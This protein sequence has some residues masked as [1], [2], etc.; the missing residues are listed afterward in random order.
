M[1]TTI[2]KYWNK[3]IPCPENKLIFYTGPGNFFGVFPEKKNDISEVAFSRKNNNKVNR[4]S[5]EKFSIKRTI[6][7]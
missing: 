4:D 7:K 5:S 3:K 6:E 2:Y 1:F